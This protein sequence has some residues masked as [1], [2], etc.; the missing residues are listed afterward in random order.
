MDFENSEKKSDLID[1]DLEDSSGAPA[2]ANTSSASAID[3]LESLFGSA[4]QA[5]TSA[6]IQLGGARP[7]VPLQTAN[8]AALYQQQ[9]QPQQPVLG[10]AQGMNLFGGGGGNANM[11]RTASPMLPFGGQGSLGSVSLGASGHSTPMG[12]IGNSAGSLWGA[13]AG[14]M[15]GQNQATTAGQGQVV[16]N[17]KDPFADLAGLF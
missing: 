1:F 16:V 10:N 13:N 3:D 9:Q 6:P 12:T 8:L 17:T 4:P 7:S 2:A 15:G 14:A 11:N 5:T